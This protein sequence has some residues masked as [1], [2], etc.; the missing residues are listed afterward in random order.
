MDGYRV[1]EC[2]RATEQTWARQV[3]STSLQGKFKILTQC[4]IIA[5]TAFYDDSVEKKAKA[6]GINKVLKKPINHAEL[7]NVLREYYY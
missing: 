7:K 4:P 2:I 3:A 1:A 5:V 6:A